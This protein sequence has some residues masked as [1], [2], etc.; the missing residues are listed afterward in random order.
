MALALHEELLIKGGLGFRVLPGGIKHWQ[1]CPV[2]PLVRLLVD[3]ALPNNRHAVSIASIVG[4]D[5]LCGLREWD[6]VGFSQDLKPR[7]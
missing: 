4:S 6:V 5:K 2:I 7:P 3:A 1:Q